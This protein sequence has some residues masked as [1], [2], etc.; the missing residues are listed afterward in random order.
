[1]YIYIYIYTQSLLRGPRVLQWHGALL[2]SYCIQG[3]R[4]STSQKTLSAPKL[5]LYVILFYTTL[6]YTIY[7]TIL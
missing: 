5:R 7:Y 6:W 4:S 3:G 1:M 2:L